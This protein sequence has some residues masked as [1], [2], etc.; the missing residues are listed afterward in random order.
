VDLAVA[1][2]QR[3]AEA[4][5]KPDPGQMEA[6]KRKEAVLTTKITFV[7]DA[8]GDSDADRTE[9]KRKLQ[10]LRAE[11]GAVQTQISEM[12]AAAGRSSAIPTSEQVHQQIDQVADV[13]FRAAEGKDPAEWGAAR[14]ILEEITGGRIVISQQGEAKAKRGWLRGTF[15][16]HPI[17][18]LAR[19]VDCDC[20]DDAG[21]AV[22]VDF[23]ELPS[24]VTMAEQV[25]VR[26]DQGMLYKDIADRMCVYRP[27][28]PKALKYWFASRGLP[29][30]DGRLR[31]FELEHATPN[32][33]IFQQI[34]DEALQLYDQGMLVTQIAE[35]FGCHYTTVTKAVQH[36][37][38]QRGLVPIDGRTR[39]KTLACQSDRVAVPEGATVASADGAFAEFAVREQA[40]AD[41]EADG[42][43]HAEDARPAV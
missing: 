37:R 8:P 21:V 42:D 38:I 35:Q 28:V 39:Y 25:K 32:A 41:G 5:G 16:A 19:T 18:L 36:A 20:H 10:G 2:C 15:Q 13:L 14:R 30:P 26:F 11:R 29:V 4:A 1:A 24:E 40:A 3:Y 43:N 7:M 17:Q 34:A 27:L 6:L 31:R 9:S 22:S 33:Y 23:R 12:E